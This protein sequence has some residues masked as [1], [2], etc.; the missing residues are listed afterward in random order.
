MLMMH[1]SDIAS[2]CQGQLIGEDQPIRS[3][4]TDSRHIAPEE[5]FIALVGDRF[6]GHHYLQQVAQCGAGAVLVS[7]NVELDIPVIRVQDTRLALGQIAAF[8]RQQ[9]SGP[10]AAI[11]GSN[12]KTTVKEMLSAILA[13][14]YNVLYTQGNFNNDIGLPL[15]LLRLNEEHQAMVLE[16]GANHPGEITYTANIAQANVAL[17][18]NVGDAHIEGFGSRTGVADEK[19]EIFAALSEQGCAV[20]ESDSP[21]LSLFKQKASDARCVSFGLEQEADIWASNAQCLSDGCYQFELCSEHHCAWV[22]LKTPG[23][24]NVKNACASAALALQMGMSLDECAKALSEF[25]GV[26]GRLRRLKLSEHITLFDDTY[27]A[28]PNSFNAALDVL[29]GRDG[30]VMLVAGD[31]GELGEQSQQAHQSLG[32]QAKARQI[33]LIATGAQMKYAVQGAGDYGHYYDD[34]PALA[35]ALLERLH[36][37]DAHHAEAMVVVKGSRSSQMEKT[38]QFIQQNFNKVHQC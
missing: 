26:S 14:K 38:V 35:K 9:F 18:N 8:Q 25:A 2:V 4:C 3:I 20:F 33:E 36:M 30:F 22:R 27:N 10:V 17:V 31:M 16:L 7:Q 21:Y 11:T 13:L 5:L 24:H 1:L 29:S 34:Q 32:E 19:S 15:T 28:N 37:L 12:G 6:D 23:L